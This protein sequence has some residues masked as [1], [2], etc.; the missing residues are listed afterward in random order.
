MTWRGREQA[1]QLN[2][3]EEFRAYLRDLDFQNGWRPSGIACHNTASPTLEQWWHGGTSPEQRMENLRYY[4][5]VEMGWSAGPHCFVDGVSY[6]IM[7]DFNV[8]GVHSPS[9]NGSRLG[10]EHVGDYD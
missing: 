7:T 9:W 6:W 1:L 8:S 10:I 4:Y 3:I 5:E 2:N